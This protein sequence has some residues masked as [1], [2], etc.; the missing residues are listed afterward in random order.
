MIEGK[1]VT[2]IILVAGNST[3]YGKNRNKNFE[4][5]NGKTVISYSLRA[6]H[7]NNYIDKMIIGA[8]ENEVTVIKDII[9]K[10]KLSK[11]IDIIIGGSSR[12]ETVYHCIQNT[13]SD[14]VIIHDGA[15]PAIKQRYI[16]ECIENMREFKGATVGVPSKDTIKITDENNIV[17]Q[18]T[19]RSNTWIVQTPQCF[20][21]KLLL[22]MHEKY[23]QEEVTDD[24]M[25]IEKNKE[26]VK[27]LEGDYTNIKITTQEDIHV[28]KEFIDKLL[29]K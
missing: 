24:C 2:A 4:I 26:K 27:I 20:E 17:M 22:E 28:V 29:A 7:E 13:K 15:R 18:S 14:I 8:K 16:N 5:I 25:L 10:E 3:R 6:F 1:E 9:Q 19:K 12:Q 23:K 11:P 21:R